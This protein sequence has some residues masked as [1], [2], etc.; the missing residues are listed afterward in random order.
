MS[1][2]IPMTCPTYD[3]RDLLAAAVDE[4]NQI[5]IEGPRYAKASVVLSQFFDAGMFTDDLC[6][7]PVRKNT[8]A[9]D[10]SQQ[11]QHDAWSR[12]S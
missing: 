11:D 1:I 10:C 4:L 7:Q 5:Y 6:S 2:S 3:T 9:L 8:E 12:I